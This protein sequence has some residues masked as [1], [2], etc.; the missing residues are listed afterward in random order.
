MSRCM[1]SLNTHNRESTRQ[2]DHFSTF[3]RY[4]LMP[5]SIWKR[6]RDRETRRDGDEGGSW[7]EWHEIW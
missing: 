5:I 7:M 3:N 1:R 2:N 4:N 6:N